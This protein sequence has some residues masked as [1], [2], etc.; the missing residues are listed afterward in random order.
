MRGASRVV[1]PARLE[2]ATNGSV[3]RLSVQLRYGLGH[4]LL[5]IGD[6]IQDVVEVVGGI[7]SAA[8]TGTSS[9]KMRSPMRGL[10]TLRMTRST[11][12]PSAWPK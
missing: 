9:A 11:L 1:R 10:R 2:R 7:A 4:E 5:G 6:R 8:H 3:D 12:T